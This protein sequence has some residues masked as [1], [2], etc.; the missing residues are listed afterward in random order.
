MITLFTIRDA[1]KAARLRTGDRT[2]G[3]HLEQGR[4][5]VIRVTYTAKGTSRIAPLTGWLSAADAL[6]VINAL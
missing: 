4:L 1:V 2:I 3:T 6:A 5:Q